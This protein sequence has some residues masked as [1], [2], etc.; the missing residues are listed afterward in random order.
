MKFS[1]V[2]LRGPRRFAGPLASRWLPADRLGSISSLKGCSKRLTP[3]MDLGVSTLLPRW[4][5]LGETKFE[6]PYPGFL[7]GHNSPLRPEDFLPVA[8]AA[9]LE[10]SARSICHSIFSFSHDS[11]LNLSLENNKATSPLF[12]SYQ[13]GRKLCFSISLLKWNQSFDRSHLTDLFQQIKK[14]IPSLLPAE[15]HANASRPP[16]ENP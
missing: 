10:M 6:T 1:P 2:G 5:S 3:Q 9:I 8:L 7:Y 13:V 11:W 12:P 14:S 16:G 15:R 4:G